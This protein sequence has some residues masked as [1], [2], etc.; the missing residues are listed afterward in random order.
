M[1]TTIEAVNATKN[2]PLSTLVGLSVAGSVIV[3]FTSINRYPRMS[4]GE[5][6]AGTFLPALGAIS[7]GYM[8]YTAKSYF[9]QDK[10]ALDKQSKTDI[11]VAGTVLIGTVANANIN[12][13]TGGG[14]FFTSKAPAGLRGFA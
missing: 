3:G 10:A 9:Q 7:T 12:Y 2:N 11:I 13:A 6:F 14:G 8:G 1:V 5:L 4:I